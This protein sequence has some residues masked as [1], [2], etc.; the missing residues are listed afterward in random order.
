MK[1]ELS[2]LI[3]ED[4]LEK[5]EQITRELKSE[6]GGLLFGFTQDNNI[7]IDD[8]KFP[9][10]EV[11]SSSV[12]F[13]EKSI[14]KI[15]KESKDWDKFLGM[16]HSH[17]SMGAFF[18]QG[19][20]AD[21]SH[22]EFISNGK[23]ITVFIVSSY[24]N[25]SF[26]YKCRVE[27]RKPFKLSIDDIDLE[28][29]KEE[30]K[31]NDFIDSIKKLIIKS[32]PTKIAE[33]AYNNKDEKVESFFFLRDK[34]YIIK[35][36]F[37]ED[38]EY[39]KTMLKDYEYRGGGLASNSKWYMIIDCDNYKKAQLIKKN[40]DNIFSNRAISVS[41]DVSLSNQTNLNYNDFY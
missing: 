31:T 9:L 33:I 14:L 37:Y 10:Q 13:D 27:I 41:K 25:K 35:N 38:Y 32:K 34:K 19:F 39:L 3:K 29:L 7:I 12:D 28:V 17:N 6:F 16:W 15:R 18:S 30:G 23:D 22:I 21:D 5:I 8:I 40:I 2:L 4:V 20:E 24:K 11:S 1:Y 36:M 26:E